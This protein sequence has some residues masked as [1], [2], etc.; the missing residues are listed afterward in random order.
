VVPHYAGI[1]QD[2]DPALCGKARDLFC[3]NF[4]VDPV[5]CS[6]ALNHDP[7][8]CGIA[9]DHDPALCRIAQDQNGIAREQLI[10]LWSHAV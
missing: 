9:Q 3:I 8:L 10:K 2:H 1:A 5:L 7:A 6:T 4:Y